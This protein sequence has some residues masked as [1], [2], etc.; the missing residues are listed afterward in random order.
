LSTGEIS[1]TDSQNP[2][3][4]RGRPSLWEP[5]YLEAMERMGMF[6]ET[7]TRRGK[8]NICYRQRAVALLGSGDNPEFHWLCGGPAITKGGQAKAWRPS[9]LVELGRINDDEML[10][11]LAR[12]MCELKPT[13]RAAVA[14]IRQFRLGRSKPGSIAALTSKIRGTI[15]AYLQ[16]R[17][18]TD[19]SQVL[20]SIAEVQD[21]VKASMHQTE[22]ATP[23]VERP[24][25]T[26]PQPKPEPP[27]PRA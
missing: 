7:T 23:P 17:P 15:N 2:R 11:A 19:L 13:S 24:P 12:R 25:L 8:N 3:R 18:D 10:L 26:L 14:A 5:G 1:E 9:V 20:Q 6:T 27:K 21:I 4:R 16:R 22:P